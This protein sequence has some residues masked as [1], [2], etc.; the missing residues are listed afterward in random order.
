MDPITLGVVALMGAAATIAGTAEDLE[1][2]V[3]SMS[4]PNS[5]V[6][7]APQ[8]GHLHRMI[9]KAISGEPVA[10]GTWCGIAGSIAF[11]LIS[12][13]FNFHVMPIIGIAIGAAVAA[14]IHTAYSVTAHMGRIVSQSQ[15]EQPL[16]MD[17]LTQALGPI[18]GH[19]FITTFCIVSL[20]YLMTIPLGG[21]IA[22]HV[23]P[24]PL[25]A[26]LWGITLGAIGSSTGDVHYGAEREYQQ[27]P[28][29][30]G[31]PVANHGDIVT[32]AEIGARNSI[33]IV[34]FCAKFG[35]PLTGFCF[36]AVVFLSFWITVVFGL[37]GGL[38]AGLII[39][40]LLIIMN[41]RLESFARNKFG[42]YKE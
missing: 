19:G 29:G 4:N 30:G 24:L 2:D 21:N 22:L 37:I 40:I 7:L 33:D 17:A 36:G 3:G 9:N 14:L 15:F 20:S 28:F 12:P 23:F 42:P 16:F 18:A 6:Q 13:M 27:Y 10:Y 35:G 26:V 11:V 34:N 39:V 8:M 38:I 25:L 5:Q 32:K 1:S 31:I 41:E